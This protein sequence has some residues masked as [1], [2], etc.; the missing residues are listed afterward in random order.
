MTISSTVFNLQS[1][2]EYNHVFMCSARLIMLY[3]CVTFHE[4]IK[5]ELQIICSKRCLM[6]IY[7]GMKFCENISNG[8]RVMERT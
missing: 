6:V 7:I 4:N 2:Q 3:I 8:F 1:R 5:P